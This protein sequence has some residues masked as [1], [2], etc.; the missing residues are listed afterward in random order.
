MNIINVGKHS[1][2]YYA[3]DIKG[4]KLLLDCGRPGT[5]PELTAALKRKSLSPA[6]IKYIL[7]THLHPGHAG[8]VQ[9]FKDLSAKLIPLESQVRATRPSAERAES[10][11]STRIPV[12]PENNILL[13]SDE[14]REFLASL[15][16]AGEI[17]TT[18]GHSDV[19]I[20]LISDD[21][22]AFTGDLR[23]RSPVSPDDLATR[24]SWDRIYLHPITKIYPAYGS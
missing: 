13:K 1:A 14:S 18:P 4:G 10:K 12:T 11:D 24:Q 5:L 22:T 7:A 19:S 20:S 3:L 2:N 8:L 17:I 23:P 21:D 15:G 16:L 9:E 6:E